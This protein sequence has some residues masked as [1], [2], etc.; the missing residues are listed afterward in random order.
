MSAGLYDP[1]TYENLT[2]SLI[3][4]FEKQRLISLERADHVP[5]G[6]GIYALYYSGKFEPYAALVDKKWAIYAGKAVLPGRRKGKESSARK[7]PPHGESDAAK[8]PALRKRIKEHHKSIE[9]ASNLDVADFQFRALP[10]LPVWISTAEEA[11][12]KHYKPL[13]NQGL[14]GFGNHP[15]GSGRT[16]GERSW[17][18][19][20][21]PG[22]TWVNELRAVKTREAAVKLVAEFVGTYVKP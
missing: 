22:R 11:M 14:D 21:H 16:R 17:W 8:S 12:I 19:T 3:L 13:W 1:L 20:L 18:D 15:Q 10:V 9:Q 2:Q 5:L 6:P 4:N 7:A